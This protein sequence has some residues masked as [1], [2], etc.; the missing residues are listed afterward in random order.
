M[1]LPKGTTCLDKLLLEDGRE[2]DFVTLVVGALTVVCDIHFYYMHQ[3]LIIH[4]DL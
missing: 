2:F 1:L 4:Y 3:K